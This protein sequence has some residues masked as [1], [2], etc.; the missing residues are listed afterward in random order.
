MNFE[1][2]RF[3]PISSDGDGKTVILF[4]RILHAG[5]FGV[6]CESVSGFTVELLHIDKHTRGTLWGRC[7]YSLLKTDTTLGFNF[8]Q[9]GIHLD[10]DERVLE[11]AG[12]V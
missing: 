5:H 7:L 11:S 2:N 8:V 6:D 12:H 1:F 4:A 3:S 9:F 10:M